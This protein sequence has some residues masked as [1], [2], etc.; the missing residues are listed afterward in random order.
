MLTVNT[1]D[2]EFSGLFYY[3]ANGHFSDLLYSVT[4]IDRDNTFAVRIKHDDKLAPNSDAHFQVA[5]LYT[6]VFGE[7]RIRVHSL[8][9]RVT[10]QL[11]DVFRGAD[12]DAL[13]NAL[14]KM[15]TRN[16]ICH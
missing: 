8:S 9:L 1:S 4:G 14:V 3:I 6:N 15:G 12:M 10:D 7:R 5:L 2:V 13:G 16:T 11:G